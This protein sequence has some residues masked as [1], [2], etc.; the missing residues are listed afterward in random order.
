M[1]KKNIMWQRLQ[2]LLLIVMI[3][4]SIVITYGFL[5]NTLQFAQVYS[6]IRIFDSME[7]ESMRK[8]QDTVQYAD[9]IEKH[10][11]K[12]TLFVEGSQY[13]WIV[14][15]CRNQTITRMLDVRQSADCTKSP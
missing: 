4:Y 12:G 11:P 8:P 5:V 15:K 10:Y 6:L 1:K 9:Y 2:C 3:L 7:Q 14:E 13:E